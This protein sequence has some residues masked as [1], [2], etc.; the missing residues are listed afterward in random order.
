MLVGAVPFDPAQDDA[1]HQP[2]RLA[3]PLQ[4]AELQPPRLQGALLAEPSPG[5]YATAVATAV[6]LLADEQVA[7]DK[8]VLA[9]SLYVHTEQP[10]APQALLARLGRDA[11]VTTYDTPLPVAAGQPPAWLVGATPELLLRRHGRQVLSH[12]LAGSARR[13]SD[14]AQDERAA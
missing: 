5:R 10:L 14:P 9:R 2:V 1:L 8:V 11:A 12:P 3:P 4:H 7:L 13:S 6:A